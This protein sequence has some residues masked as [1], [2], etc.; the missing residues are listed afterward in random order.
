MAHDD[1]I[2]HNK[3]GEPG[4]RIRSRL[5]PPC[6]PLPQR[7]RSQPNSSLRS[8]TAKPRQSANYNPQTSIEITPLTA[9]FL[10]ANPR[11]SFS[12]THRKISPLKISNRERIAIFH[13]PRLTATLSTRSSGFHSS[14]ITRHSSLTCPEGGASQRRV[15][16]H[17]LNR[18]AAIFD[19]S[20]NGVLCS[21]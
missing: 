2:T 1:K 18:P 8:V 7:K 12:V 19:S 15:T 3:K 9:H 20:Y 11:L 5:N 14:L 21:A 17:R 6:P 13:S 4:L 16:R 10:I